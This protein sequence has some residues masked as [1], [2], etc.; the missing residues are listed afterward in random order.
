MHISVVNAFKKHN[1][2]PA[3]LFESSYN[4][5]RIVSGHPYLDRVHLPDS[6]VPYQSNRRSCL[7]K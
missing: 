6:C 5:V 1:N 7:C 2:V 3:I 4:I